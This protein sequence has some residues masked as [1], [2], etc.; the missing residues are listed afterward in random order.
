VSASQTKLTSILYTK[1]SGPTDERNTKMLQK[2]VGV[3]HFLSCVVYDEKIIT[4]AE[5]IC[6]WK[7]QTASVVGD[8]PEVYSSLTPL[9]LSVILSGR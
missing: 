4:R 2:K 8:L 7:R 1:A 3:A 5:A 6:K 9:V